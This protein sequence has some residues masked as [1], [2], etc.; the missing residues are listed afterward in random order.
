MVVGAPELERRPE[1]YTRRD[2]GL[3]ALWALDPE[4]CWCCWPA[5]DDQSLGSALLGGAPELVRWPDVYL[6]Q[7]RVLQGLWASDLCGFGLN[8]RCFVSIHI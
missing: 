6:G 4:S 1:G 8:V 7:G 5:E 3:P 2:R